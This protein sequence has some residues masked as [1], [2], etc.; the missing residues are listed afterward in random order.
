[1]A[2]LNGDVPPGSASPTPAS[3]GQDELVLDT[4]SAPE[5]GQQPSRGQ[6]DLP[7]KQT[8]SGL[9]IP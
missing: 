5:G 1:M 9:Y 2:A 4:H 3:A 7:G 8:S 6:G